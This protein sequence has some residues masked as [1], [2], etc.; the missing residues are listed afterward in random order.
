ML[1][2][3]QRNAVAVDHWF[4]AHDAVSQ[5]CCAHCFIATL[6]VPN[7]NRISRFTKQFGIGFDFL[8]CNFTFYTCT[9]AGILN[10]QSGTLNMYHDFGD[11]CTS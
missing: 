2:R 10:E 7:K 5:R 1:N 8:K 4:G 9:L 6:G 3:Y 11:F